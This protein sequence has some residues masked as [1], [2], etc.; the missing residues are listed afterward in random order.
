[1][2]DFAVDTTAPVSTP[3]SSWISTAPY[4]PR[5]SELEEA[6]KRT[7]LATSTATSVIDFFAEK[8]GPAAPTVAPSSMGHAVDGFT[9]AVTD[10]SA[11]PVQRTANTRPSNSTD[12]LANQRVRLLAAKY[13]NKGERSEIVARL[14]ILNRRLSE[15]LPRVTAEQVESLERANDV[16]AKIRASRTERAQRL[17]IVLKA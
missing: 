11:P 13:A 17:G 8:T 4:D 9:K 6:S 1:M 16:L 2:F 15:Q 10:S 14:E 12:V 5:R 3:A 7:F